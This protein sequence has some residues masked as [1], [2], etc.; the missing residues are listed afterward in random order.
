MLRFGGLITLCRSLILFYVRWHCSRGYGYIRSWLVK[1]V[2]HKAA[3][4]FLHVSVWMTGRC[5][6]PKCRLLSGWCSRQ[7]NAGR[8]DLQ[9]WGNV[10]SSYWIGLQ[11]FD[12]R[13]V[14]V[15][16]WWEIKRR[17]RNWDRRRVRRRVCFWGR[18]GSGTFWYLLPGF[19]TQNAH[20]PSQDSE[21]VVERPSRE[22]IWN[23][24]ILFQAVSA[25]SRL[26]WGSRRAD[27]LLLEFSKNTL[28][29]YKMTLIKSII[30]LK[31]LLPGLLGHDMI[32]KPFY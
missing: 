22:D 17:G 16:Y 15:R 29:V 20:L 24:C 31:E 19:S 13:W 21:F 11:I 6:S 30:D 9:V 32:E 7:G 4:D 28:K 1:E 18:N 14:R 25:F 10:R 8:Q 5:C 12:Q 23:S 27:C 2:S 26:L 3:I